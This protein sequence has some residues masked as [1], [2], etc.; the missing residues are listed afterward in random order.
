MQTST[1]ATTPYGNTAMRPGYDTGGDTS[2]STAV[3]GRTA[4]GARRALR[5]GLAR[6]S[7]THTERR[8][9]PLDAMVIGLGWFSVALG[10]AELMAPRGL[11]RAVGARRRPAL[12]R[13]FGAR[14]LVAGVGLL[15]QADSTP[16]LW[17]RVAGDA[18]DLAFLAGSMVGARA[19]DRARLGGAIAAVAGV[20]AVDVYAARRASSGERRS[21]P[22][23]IRS[24]GSVRVE[25]SLAVNQPPDACYAMWR[26][27]A[28]LPRFMKNLQS[29]EPRADGRSH[30]IAK[31]PTGMPV[32]WDAEITRDEPNALLSWRALPGSELPN[33]GAV[34]FIA[35]P[36]GHGTIVSVTMQY[37]PPAGRLGLTLARLLGESP[38]H[39][40][41]EDLRRFKALLETGEIP[42]TEGQAH[43]A[44]S[45]WYKAVEGGNR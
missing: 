14:E 10:V 17:S 43:G 4:R 12:T 24:D 33:A 11:A 27:L 30:W 39:D 28:N 13:F 1:S 16:W 40:V 29:V 15:T 9:D 20:T 42:T 41:R 3:T 35:A 23:S 6:A 36:G 7:A 22:G 37:E 2:A 38:A 44:R 25:E 32:E 18:M 5:P 19:S 8:R 34:R 21:A 45:L 31:G 26:D